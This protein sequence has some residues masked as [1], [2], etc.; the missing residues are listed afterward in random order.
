MKHSGFHRAIVAI[1]MILIGWLPSLAHDFVVDGIFYNKTSYNTVAVTYKG[2]G[3]YDYSDEY[4]GDVV[5]P[6]SVN[7]NGVTYSVT[8]IGDYA[9]SGCYSLTSIQIPNSV[10]SIGYS[11]FYDCSSLTSAE[12]GNSVTSIGARAFF[13]CESLTSI[14]IPN[15]VTSIGKQAFSSCSS[16]TSIVVDAGNSIYDSR[17][18]CNAIIETASNT[19]IAGCQN[20]II[21]NSVTSIGEWAFS[22]CR[23][24]TS[25]EIPNSVTRIGAC[26]FQS[27]SLLRSVVIGNSVTRIGD[28]AFAYCSS[29]TS[30][31]IPNSVTSIEDYAFSYCESLTS[32]EIPNSVTSIGNKA[33]RGCYNLTSVEI[34]NSVTSIGNEAFALCESL[35]SIQIPNS[36]TS[37]GDYAF[38]SCESL[39]SIQIPNSVT[40]IGDYAFSYC[41]SL[42]SIQIPN[43]VT[44][45]GYRTFYC[46]TSLTSVVIPNSV[47]SIGDYAFYCCTSLTSIQIPNSV[48]SIGGYA[49][50]L[51]KSLTS[52]EIPNSVTSIG[53]SAFELCTSLT[54]IEIPNSVTSI[55][56][57]AF[58][59][60]YDLTKITCL[61]M[62]PP[63]IRL[64]TFNSYSAE[65]YVPAG[66][67]SAYQSANHWKKF[68][69]K[70][71]PTLST[72]IALNQTTATLKATETLT[73]V[74][75]VLPENATDK[76]VTWKSSNEA[77]ATV[78][79][80]GL[81][82]AIGVGETTITATTT[83]GSN[84]T[85]SCK[86]TVVPTLAE[87][88]TLDKTEIRLEATETATLV[89]TVLPELTTDKSIEWSSSD[90]TVAEVD[91]NGV[92]TAITLGEATI[93]ATTTDGSDLSA[94]CNVTVVPTLAETITLD[95]TEIS[96]EA[97]ETSTLVATVLP[98]LTTDKSVEWS[99]SDES[100]AVVDE[101]GV[102][103]AI[104]VGEATIT[105]T[106]A[107]GSNLSTSCKVTVVPTLAESIALDKTEISLEATETA[108][109]VA[110]ILP[111]LTTDKSVKW[112]SS[113]ETVAVVD[114]NGVVTAIAVGEATITATTAD[115]SNLSA[116]CKIIVKPTLATSITLDYSEYE[117]VEKSDFQLVATILP[118]LATNKGVVWSS[119]DMWVASV[120][121]NGLVRAYSV[122]E[123]VITATTIDGSNL[124][125][126]CKVTVVSSLAQSI[127]L[128]KTE[129]SL[130]ATETAT[131]VAT[132]L[133]ETTSNKSVEW[134][135]SDETVAVVDENGVVTAI[136]VGEAIITATTVD[137]SNL[138]ATCK[139]T[140]IPTLAISIELDQT[141]ASVEEKS[142]LQLTATILPEHTT[143]KEV[144]WSS[145]DKWVA[146]VDNT[147]LVTIYSAGEVVI[148]A[149][150]T[151][152]TNLS[153]TC[154]INVYSGIDGAEGDDLIVA[155]IGDNIVVKNAQLGSIVRV[156][157]ADGSIIS[158]EV[159]TDGDVVV[160][161]PIK[162]VY[163]VSVNGKT[164]KVMVK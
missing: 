56:N 91:E 88:I 78:D 40:S 27:C 43:S 5:I 151:D 41:E 102:V 35:T 144:A 51:C 140:V 69:I 153:A 29:L 53:D 63:R 154:R 92:V 159:A 120:D 7:Y 32:I 149:T 89:A 42:T 101:N 84:L 9:F 2:E 130:K 94:S 74:A 49:F 1:A 59:N 146:S 83:D 141:E 104:S 67:I 137:D 127:T 77:V 157:A 6:S 152:G 85:A 158:S 19:L 103:T 48:T 80:N 107:D 117:I 105:A 71:I 79:A 148:T 10:T 76:S 96:L 58:Y 66:C 93:T 52:I 54:S 112:S 28:S 3:S 134:S 125:A 114:E 160:E 164:F 138:S 15:S 162:G 124:S 73:L 4:A 150:T 132:V 11:A 24:L 61:A 142:D 46:C 139:V 133:P 60:C 20:T 108:T 135:S 131:L 97:T 118:E 100:V 82:T 99:S 145:S 72:S 13:Y 116:S 21:P 47:T 128:D 81:V 123:A 65:L 34:G 86:V 30:I 39:A 136:A 115:G 45:I 36:V 22:S 50:E 126:S 33:F 147:G 26:A 31:E 17:N 57:Y 95:K 38:S 18:D 161:A 8:S 62:T 106:T 12:I 121:E 44:S 129:V 75:T 110:T 155:T 113:D 109:L 98:E 70:E 156:Y 143:N 14:V 163:I 55:E 90:E 37:I 87:S 25:I 23:S 16:L 111:E 122:G 119:S 68:N 64:S